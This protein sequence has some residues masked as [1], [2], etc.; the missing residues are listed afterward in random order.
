MINRLSNGIDDLAAGLRHHR[1]WVALASEDIT[2]QHRRTSL[3]PFWLLVNYLAF[4]ATFIMFFNL[5]DGSAY[6]AV[7][8]ATG[9]LVW[10]YIAEV[11]TVSVNLFEREQSFIT[12]TTLPISVYVFRA[13]LQ[14]AIRAGYALGGWVLVMLFC[15]VTPQPGWLL[16]L[17]GIAIVLIA[18][19]PTI[20]VCAFC[21]LV[22][23][24]SQH[25]INN[26]MRIGMFVT[27]VFWVDPGIGGVRGL[28]Y[29]YNPFTYFLDIVRVPVLEGRLSLRALVACVLVTLVMWLLALLLLGKYRRRVSLLL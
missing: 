24:D 4:V 8:A 5:G 26:L 1:V 2:D 7:Y 10:L 22:F 25:I 9:L 15:G 13:A 19:P 18:T 27:P 16:A 6:Y 11:V 28:F 12:G 17:L 29:H 21:G 23:P 3:G 14:S 20:I